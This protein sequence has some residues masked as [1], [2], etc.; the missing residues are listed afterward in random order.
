MRVRQ[1]HLVYW[2]PRSACIIRPGAT[3]QPSV[4][5]H[6]VKELGITSARRVVAELS[7]RFML[8]KAPCR[9]SK[10]LDRVVA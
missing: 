6:R 8:C 7:H 9:A 5:R 1:T 4:N 10:F 2:L 3:Q